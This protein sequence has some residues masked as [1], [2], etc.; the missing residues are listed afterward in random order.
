M[1]RHLPPRR[2]GDPRP[3]PHGESAE[4]LRAALSGLCPTLL[5][6]EALIDRVEARQ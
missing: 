2:P 6:L 1:T 5:R 4:I 3:A